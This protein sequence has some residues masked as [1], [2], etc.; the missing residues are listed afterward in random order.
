MEVFYPVQNDCFENNR[1]TNNLP[2]IFEYQMVKNMQANK[3]LFSFHLFD[4][5]ILVLQGFIGRKDAKFTLIFVHVK[6][7]FFRN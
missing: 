2:T 5:T 3:S 6:V 7:L 1:P 4:K